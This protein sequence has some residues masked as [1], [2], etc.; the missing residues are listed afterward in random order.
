MTFDGYTEAPNCSN[1]SGQLIFVPTGVFRP[2]NV[3]NFSVLNSGGL[4]GCYFSFEKEELLDEGKPL[5]PYRNELA[6]IL[7]PTST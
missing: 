2:M 7:S 3:A 4:A 6:F 5:Y 1:L